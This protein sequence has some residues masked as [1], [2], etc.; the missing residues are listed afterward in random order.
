MACFSAFSS[1]V[2]AEAFEL[3]TMS[4]TSLRKDA[5]SISDLIAPTARSRPCITAMFGSDRRSALVCSV[6]PIDMALI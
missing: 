2:R 3:E 4:G 5:Y 6:N 1:I